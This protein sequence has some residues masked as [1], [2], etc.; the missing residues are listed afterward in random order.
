MTTFVRFVAS[1][2]S[3][4]RVP[5]S[6]GTLFGAK[7]NN[8]LKWV[9]ESVS[10]KTLFNFF[11]FNCRLDLDERNV[12]FPTLLRLPFERSTG[13]AWMRWAFIVWAAVHWICSESRKPSRAVSGEEWMNMSAKWNWKIDWYWCESST[14]AYEAEQLLKEVDIHSVTGNLKSFLRELPEALFTDQYY[15]KVSEHYS[16]TTCWICIHMASHFF[17]SLCSFLIPS[18]NLTI[19][20]RTQESMRFKRFSKNYLN[21]IRWQ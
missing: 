5:T 8:I 1:D 21:Q 4:R 16:W 13:V 10:Q 2:V 9:S 19:P 20:M 15:Q 14:D 11:W 17:P 12:K 18:T 6:T 3:L 7:L